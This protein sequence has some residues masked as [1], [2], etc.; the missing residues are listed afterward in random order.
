M[1]KEQEDRGDRSHPRP[2][3]PTRARRR[4]RATKAPARVTISGERSLV[5]RCLMPLGRCSRRPF[6]GAG[7]GRRPRVD[8]RVRFRRKHGAIARAA[9]RAPYRPPVQPRARP[10]LGRANP[11]RAHARRSLRRRASVIEAPLAP[12]P[13]AARDCGWYDTEALD[14]LP[15]RIDLL[16]VDGRRARSPRMGRPATRRCRCCATPCDGALVILDDIHRPGERAVLE[17]WRR[18]LGTKFEPLARAHRNRCISAQPATDR[19]C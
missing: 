18:E 15:E 5:E 13:L 9:R 2:K 4:R 17:R 3:A 11:A 6:A 1:V 8:R 16:L 19:K 14:L 10:R 7:R 12:H